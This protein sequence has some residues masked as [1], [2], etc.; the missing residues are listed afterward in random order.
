MS[1]IGIWPETAPLVEMINVVVVLAI[2]MEGRGSILKSSSWSAFVSN[3]S[4]VT[5]DGGAPIN[6]VMVPPVLIALLTLRFSIV[7]V[8]IFAW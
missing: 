4:S 6:P 2:A 5:M 1:G 8:A 3:I 7:A